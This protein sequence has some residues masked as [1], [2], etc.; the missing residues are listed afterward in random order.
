MRTRRHAFGQNFLHHKPTIEKIV[1]L[2]ESELK[3]AE[4]RG[5]APK[6]ILEVGPGKRAITDHLLQ[7][8]QA[9]S[10][11]LVLVER[12]RLL[13]EGLLE[14]G[15][16]VSLH[17]MD[18]ATEHFANL[19]D[20]LVA[21]N[22]APVLFVSNLPYSAASQIL[23]QLCYK[24]QH[25]SSAVVMVQKEM[26]KRIAAP[27]GTSHRGSLSLLIQ[28]YFDAKIAFDVGP[29]AF[30]PPP[31][32]TSTVLTLTPLEKPL[33]AD[34]ADPKKFERFCQH[35]FSQRR[36]MIR[37]TLPPAAHQCFP[38]LGINGTERPEDLSL[39]AIIELFKAVH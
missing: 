25:V 9:H 12:D 28:S 20:E 26:A 35:L 36:K 23:A 7:V 2:A 4:N 3:Q 31:K 38:K 14:M 22:S 37:K 34:F 10:V 15:D 16:Q 17:F 6:S 30:N 1:S 8:A 24:S 33:T 19:F 18:A 5:R 39:S 27:E 11:P 13:E 21:K 32:V 29:G